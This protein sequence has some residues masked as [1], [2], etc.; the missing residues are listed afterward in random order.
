MARTFSD[1]QEEALGR[2]FT[3]SSFPGSRV[4]QYLNDGAH[5]IARRV[6]IPALE[7]VQSITTVAG[8]STYSPSSDRVRILGVS[9]TDD[10]DPLDEIDATD[11]DD[12]DVSSGKPSAFAMWQGSYILYPTPDAAYPLQVRELSNTV[13]VNPTDTT[14]AVGFPDDYSPALV[15][16][17]RSWLFL[18]EDDL[19]ASAGYEAKFETEVLRLKA[20][21]HRQSPRRVRRV[22]DRRLGTAAP[23]PQIPRP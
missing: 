21:V 20:D 16:Y 14:D 19:E 1:L 8:Q 9:N 2:D 5:K 3:A 18:L 13:F 4:G 11:L 23:R 17:T 7:Q 22:G 15:L 10:R 6:H 12:L